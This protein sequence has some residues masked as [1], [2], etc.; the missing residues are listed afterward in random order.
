[1]IKGKL[2]SSGA[3]TRDKLFVRSME[4]LNWYYFIGL[5]GVKAIKELYT[6]ELA[7]RIWP[8]S[9]RKGYN[10]NIAILRGEAVPIARWGD[11]YFEKEWGWLLSYRRHRAQ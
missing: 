10:I 2:E 6:P 1:M 9:R 3:F 7:S 8:K 5:W 4:R 11:E